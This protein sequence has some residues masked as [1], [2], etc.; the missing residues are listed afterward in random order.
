MLEA[1][2]ESVEDGPN[3][4]T[5]AN[6]MQLWPQKKSVSDKAARRANQKCKNRKVAKNFFRLNFLRSVTSYLPVLRKGTIRQDKKSEGR[7]SQ[8]T[9]TKRKQKQHVM[10]YL[11]FF[12]LEDAA[13][14]LGL[15]IFGKVGRHDGNCTNENKKIVI[16]IYYTFFAFLV[17]ST[18]CLP[19]SDRKRGR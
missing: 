9:T 11:P 7:T 16:Q 8:G 5:I 13:W 10:S 14:T 1:S 4:R 17:G 19:S 15:A 18:L 12:R 3:P 2:S 6:L